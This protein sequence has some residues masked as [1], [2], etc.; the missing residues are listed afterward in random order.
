ME[1]RRRPVAEQRGELPLQT[2]VGRR[3]RHMK[4]AANEVTQAMGLPAEAEHQVLRT[5]YGGPKPIAGK[6][7]DQPASGETTALPESES[8]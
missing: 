4:Q 5:L 2:R 7:T 8:K 1:R 6:P 3:L